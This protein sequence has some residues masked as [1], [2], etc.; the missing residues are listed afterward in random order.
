[1]I[2]PQQL[3]VG[4]VVAFA[5][6]EIMVSA[7]LNAGVTFKTALG[8]SY[9]SFKDIEPVLLTSTVI[10]VHGFQKAG[11]RY[12]LQRLFLKPG[13]YAPSD[14][15]GP[16]WWQFGVIRNFDNEE[17]FLRSISHLHELQNILSLLA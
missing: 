16:I 5:G 11:N 1:M 8:K 12:K 6:E 17:F 9:A 4:N 10:E 14:R 2:N 3:Q 13:P 7:I 15:E